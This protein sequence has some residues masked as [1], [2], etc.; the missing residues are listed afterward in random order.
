MSTGRHNRNALTATDVNRGSAWD[1]ADALDLTGRIKDLESDMTKGE[2]D[3]KSA[4]QTGT[5][6]PQN[7]AHGL[8]VVP[9]L[10]L[11][12]PT[13]LTGGAYDVAE[14]T[15]TDTNVVVTVT[16]GEKF[17]VYAKE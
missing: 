3:F 8:G 15:H 9:N 5:G 7:V 1:G 10:V 12:I 2:N 11:V 4:E 13:E 16:N 6:A 17:V 14:G